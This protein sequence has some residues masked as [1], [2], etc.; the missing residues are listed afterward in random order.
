METLQISSK[1]VWDASTTKVSMWNIFTNL[2][3]LSEGSLYD[4]EYPVYINENGLFLT[5]DY[6]RFAE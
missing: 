6:I 4:D 3:Y 1:T 5:P 2:K